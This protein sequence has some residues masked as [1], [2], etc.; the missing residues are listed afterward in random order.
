[1]LKIYYINKARALIMKNN[2]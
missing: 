1:M 2:T